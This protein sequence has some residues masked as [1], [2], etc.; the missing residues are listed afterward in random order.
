MV[1]G[2]VSRPV[3]SNE[4]FTSSVSIQ[5]GAT[6]QRPNLVQVTLYELRD[7]DSLPQLA[8]DFK[9][10]SDKKEMEDRPKHIQTGFIL[11]NYV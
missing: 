6:N 2:D 8:V 11:N 4:F 7:E 1:W 5:K 10:R 3:E 9:T